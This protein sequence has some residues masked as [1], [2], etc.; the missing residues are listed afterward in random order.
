M[1]PYDGHEV[2]MPIHSVSRVLFP[3]SMIAA[4]CSASAHSQAP[5]SFHALPEKPAIALSCPFRHSLDPARNLDAEP[6]RVLVELAMLEVDIGIGNV[7]QA[8]PLVADG[9]VGEKALSFTAFIN[10]P[11]VRVPGVLTI[12]IKNEV[13]HDVP[14]DL[15]HVDQQPE[16]STTNFGRVSVV[17]HMN[18]YQPT[19]VRLEITIGPTNQEPSNISVGPNS[20]PCRVQTTVTVADQQVVVLG[21]FNKARHDNK[22]SV[23]AITPYIIWSDDDLH[24]LF[25]C[26]QR[27][28]QSQHAGK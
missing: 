25:E 5:P 28:A 17:A 9:K 1:V 7:S 13:R 20:D 14:W 3:L 12:L 2:L 18:A 6:P 21:D 15:F 10:G 19:A 8:Y 16:C 24:R 23:L 27:F 22:R 4:G 11:G 26:K